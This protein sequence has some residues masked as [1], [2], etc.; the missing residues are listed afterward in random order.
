MSQ[1]PS[2]DDIGKRLER[3][4][5][6]LVVSLKVGEKT[7]FLTMNELPAS[8]WGWESMRMTRRLVSEGEWQTAASAFKGVHEW[9]EA[10][11]NTERATAAPART[12]TTGVRFGQP[13]EAQLDA[14][15]AARKLIVAAALY[16]S[17]TV[18][19]YAI[20][21]AF[22]GMIEVRSIYLLKGPSIRD[23][24]RWPLCLGWSGGMGCACL[25]IGTPF[26][27]PL[28]G[29]SPLFTRC[30]RKAAGPGATRPLRIRKFPR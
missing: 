15:T 17:A 22:H 20:E 23:P 9:I 3:A 2:L 26:L 29:R 24:R 6:E 5:T 11:W 18:A 1:I 14:T 25:A 13:S 19:K 10:Y 8:Y 28:R 4:Q 12:V 30:H 27:R 16:G 21:F 7:E